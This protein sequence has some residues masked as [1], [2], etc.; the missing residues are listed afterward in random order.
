MAQDAEARPDCCSQRA[1]AVPGL[2]GGAVSLAWGRP[3]ALQAGPE[4]WGRPLRTACRGV[5][6]WWRGGEASNPREGSER[7]GG[8]RAGHFGGRG[9]GRDLGA[10]P[11]DQTSWLSQAS[12]GAGAM[13]RYGVFRLH[14]ESRRE[15]LY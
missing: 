15:V 10:T 4:G 1:E 12:M 13:H 8:C 14:D 7:R 11:P 6:D 5:V 3:V 9:K 2:T